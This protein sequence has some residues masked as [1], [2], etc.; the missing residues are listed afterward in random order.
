MNRGTAGG[1]T[2][3]LTGLPAAGKTT[4]ATEIVTVLAGAGRAA[5]L[6]D[7][8]VMRRE[9]WPELGFERAARAEMSRRVCTRALTL[10]DDGAIAVVA[11]VCPFAE[12]RDRARDVH[13]R[14]GVG[15]IE[16][17]LDTP[18]TVCR[19]RDPK[20]LYA[21]HAR[22]E[23]SGL[24]GVDAPYEPPARPELRLPPQPLEHSVRAVLA[25]LRAAG[26]AAG[27]GRLVA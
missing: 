24:T 15:F 20:G 27:E 23:L 14:G 19:E 13:T 12:D 5:A 6:L 21:R 22:G 18:V 1:G 7:G 11:L 10:A 25:E 17:H 26:L 8:D 9:L 3:W 4:L 2:V 16:V